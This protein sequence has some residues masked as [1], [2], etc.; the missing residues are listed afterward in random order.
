MSRKTIAILFS[1]MML[2]IAATGCGSGTTGEANATEPPVAEVKVYSP[3]E[4]TGTD[5]FQ[6]VGRVK[7][8]R[9]STIASK[10]MGM[11]KDISVKSGD[12]I[13]KGQML[14]RIDE[15]DIAG[16]VQQ[17]SGALA[18]AKAALSISET[19]YNRFKS[20]FESGSASKAE[21]DKATFDYET[22]KGAVK[23][24]QGALAEA[25]SY[26]SEAR[27]R[28][29]FDG[30]VVD[31][32]IEEGE[33]VAPGRP[34]VRVEGKSALE[35]ETTVNERDIN[36][37]GIGEKVPVILDAVSGEKTEIDGT[38]SEIVPASDGT[39]SQVVRIALGNDSDIRSGLFG[40]AR[41]S[42]PQDSSG[43]VLVPTD[44]IIH[45]GQL[46]GVYVVDHG[47]HIRLRLVR[48]GRALGDHTEVLSG[49]LP[50]DRI[51]TS[52]IATLIDGQQAKVVQ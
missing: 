28:A 12:K 13:K 33:M 10:V 38:I 51:V 40:R 8:V 9:E 16:K 32:M 47:D 17:A 5:F 2:T 46:S 52:E 49:I 39:H 6:T 35:F 31:T 7:N 24:A 30:V 19:N 25:S 45:R 23:Q 11:V 42:R 29:P 14:M 43:S 27:I 37:I 21:F 22:A 4:G 36:F 48:Q 44:R 41:F 18:Q 34:L 1:L 26:L 20:L 15:Q 3:A 50:K